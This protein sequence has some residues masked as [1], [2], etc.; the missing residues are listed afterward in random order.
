MLCYHLLF[1]ENDA[2]TFDIR[3]VSDVYAKMALVTKC[4]RSI[5]PQNGTGA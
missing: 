3:R 1:T 2:V 5:R 4:I